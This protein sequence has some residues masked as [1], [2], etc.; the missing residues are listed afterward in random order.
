MY[1]FIELKHKLVEE[2]MEG[3]FQISQSLMQKKVNYHENILEIAVALLKDH[4][5]YFVLHERILFKGKL[6]KFIGA[7]VISEKSDLI[8]YLRQSIQKNDLRPIRI[9]SIEDNPN[10]LLRY[11]DEG[12]AQLFE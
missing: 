5:S 3:V 7:I 12:S 1:K 2:N 6:V 8:E 11:T 9:F 4:Q 10:F